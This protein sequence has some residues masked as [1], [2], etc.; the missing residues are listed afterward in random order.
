MKILIV[1]T[2]DIQGGAARAAYRLH[3]ALHSQ[4][5]DCTMLSN[6]KNSDDF[7]VITVNNNNK[8]KIFSKIAAFRDRLLLKKYPNKT[9]TLFSANQYSSGDA[10][11]LINEQQADIVHLHWVNHGMLTIDDIAKIN[12]PIVWSLHDNW[13]FTGGCHIKWDCERYKVNCG[14]C[15]RL[16]SNKIHD[17]SREVWLRKSKVYPSIKNLTIV[18]LSRWITELSKKS[19]LLKEKT[20]VNIP[21]L[22]DAKVFYPFDSDK[23]RELW[24]LPKDK[25]LVLFG[26]MSAMSDINKGYKQLIEAIGEI[27]VTNIAFVIFGSSTPEKQPNLGCDIYYVGHLNDDVSLTTLYSAVN[28][29]VVPSL[30]ENLSNV[31]MESLACATPVVAFSIGGNSD[32]ITHKN[33]GYLAKPFDTSDLADGI[34]WVLDNDKYEDLCISAREKVMQEFDSQVVADKYISLYQDILSD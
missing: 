1:N 23:S 9:Q 17:L 30:Q 12:A 7:S 5:I 28:V 32:L 16:N 4:S 22:I 15:P 27:N 33:N 14:S 20:H 8:K 29:M 18:G 6:E 2:S 31:I 25:K 34:K 11:K 3:H 26:A 13:A 21:N 10:I 19:S 24:R